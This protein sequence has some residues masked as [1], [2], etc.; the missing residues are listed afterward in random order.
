M[1]KK[2][3]ILLSVLL[4]VPMLAFPGAAAASNAILCADEYEITRYEETY[5]GEKLVEIEEDLKVHFVNHGSCDAYNVTATISSSPD[6]VEHSTNLLELGDLLVG[7]SGSWSDVPFTVVIDMDPPPPPELGITWRVEYDDANGVHHVIENVPQHCPGH[8]PPLPGGEDPPPPPP[9]PLTMDIKVMTIRWASD[10]AGCSWLNK[11]IFRIWGRIELPE[12]CTLDDLKK[13]A[14][15]SIAIG[16]SSGTDTVDLRERIP[17]RL[18]GVFW[19]YRGSEQP[20][21]EN[22]NITRMVVWWAPEDSDWAGKAGF[23]IAGVLELPDTI[24][25]GTEPPEATVTLSIGADGCAPMGEETLTFRVRPRLNRW[26]YWSRLPRFPCD[27]NG[28]E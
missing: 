2:I 15:A 28:T 26:V 4:V 9:T 12:C 17:R 18:P 7:G 24:G 21:G 16:G 23:Y 5:E 19:T 1:K 10:G 27:P 25:I 8:I 3:A 22:M 11:D 13:E 20:P 6:F 14:T